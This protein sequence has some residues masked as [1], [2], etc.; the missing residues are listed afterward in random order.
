MGGQVQHLRPAPPCRGHAKSSPTS[1][2]SIQD[3]PRDGWYVGI[4]FSGRTHLTLA[5]KG[6]SLHGEVGLNP[7]PGPF[8]TRLKPGETFET[9]KIFLGATSGGPDTTGNVLHRWIREVLTNQDTW[10]DPH[11]PFTVNNSWG[12]GMRGE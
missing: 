3:Y 9:P 12:G 2:L 7:N 6:D 5:R 11:Y 1:W 10:K 8:L 4:E